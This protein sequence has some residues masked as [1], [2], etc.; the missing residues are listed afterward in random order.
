VLRERWRHFLRTQIDAGRSDIGSPYGSGSMIRCRGHRAARGYPAGV[1]SQTAEDRHARPEYHA[2]QTT[3]R[4]APREQAAENGKLPDP[5][6]LTAK[7]QETDGG[8]ND[9][10]PA[11]F[12]G[13][14]ARTS[15]R[16]GAPRSDA[17]PA[18]ISNRRKMPVK[19]K[20]D[21]ATA[22][23]LPHRQRSRGRIHDDP[24]AG[25]SDTPTTP[26]DS[27]RRY[28]LA[29]KQAQRRNAESR[30]TNPLPIPAS[31]RR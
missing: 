16:E 30:P 25:D 8:E 27:R 29:R 24:V 14:H 20:P 26:P 15:P 2:T 9:H 17:M 19:E 23:R 1:R 10:E 6:G 7:D 18:S 3:G 11:S 22:R 5:S 4:S 28:S 21:R 13:D 12:L 31:R